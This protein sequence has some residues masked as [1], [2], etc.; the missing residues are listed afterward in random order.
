MQTCVYNGLNIQT[1]L[2]VYHDLSHTVSEYYDLGIL[3]V[4][5]MICVYH[6]QNIRCSALFVYTTYLCV[7]HG[8]FI[9]GVNCDFSL[10]C[11]PYL[12]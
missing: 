12:N 3:G 9:L 7:D 10:L 6:D 2:C 4:C 1:Y 11:V 5:T 8:W